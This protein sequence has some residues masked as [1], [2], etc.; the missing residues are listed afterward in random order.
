MAPTGLAGVGLRAKLSGHGP[1]DVLIDNPESDR[2]GVALVQQR[3]EDT[4]A[5]IGVRMADTINLHHLKV[6]SAAVAHHTAPGGLEQMLRHG[7]SST[8]VRTGALGV[9]VL[10]I[11]RQ[12]TPHDEGVD[13]ATSLSGKVLGGTK[14]QHGSEVTGADVD[15]AHH[16]VDELV[17]ASDQDTSVLGRHC[18]G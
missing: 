5:G 10:Q 18:E 4:L 1:S 7:G 9:D 16:G 14:T 8:V 15:V 11:E 12:E 3:E 17:D 13:D 6:L 2:P